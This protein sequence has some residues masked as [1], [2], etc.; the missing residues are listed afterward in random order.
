MSIYT[1]YNIVADETRRLVRSVV[2]F[3]CLVFCLR[4]PMP[5]RA[6]GTTSTGQASEIYKRAKDQFQRGEY[7]LAYS[8]FTLLSQGEK[9]RRTLLP[10]HL[11]VETEY[12]EITC[13]LYLDQFSAQAKAQEF[14]NY[15]N[16]KPWV[17]LMA[18]QLAEYY[19]RKADYA[20]ALEYYGKSGIAN[21]SNAQIAGMKFHKAY[22]HF[23][24]KQFMEAK[25]LF[26]GIRQLPDD[27]NY[28]ASNYYFGFISFSEKKYKEAA[29]AFAIAETKQPYDKFV[30]FY[31]SEILYFNNEK[32]KALALAEKNLK[33]GGQFYELQL[34]QLAG[35]IYLD[36]RDYKKALP[37]LEEYV[38]KTPKPDRVD[39]YQLSYCYYEAGNWKKCI[40]GFQTLGGKEDS[41]AQNSMYLLADAYL[42]TDKKENAR[43]AFLFCATNSSNLSQQEVSA[44]QYAKISFDLGY[45]DIAMSELKKF[46]INYPQSGYQQEAKELMVATLAQGSNYK[47]S[48]ELFESLRYQSDQVKRIYPRILYGRAVELYNDRQIVLADSLFNKI[49]KAAFNHQQLPFTYYWKGEIAYKQEQPD[50]A[51]YYFN[52][53]LI[54]PLG[55]GDVNT[56]NA[57]YTL[58][59]AYLKKGDFKSANKYYQEVAPSL[60]IGSTEVQRDAYLRSGDCFYMGRQYPKANTVYEEVHSH[61]LKGE[62]YAF[63]QQAMI[64]GATNKRNEKLRLLE[65]FLMEYPSS[66]LA[67]EANMELADYL[68]VDEKYAEALVPLNKVVADPNAVNVLPK[69]KLKI[70]VCY[71]NTGKPDDALKLFS[72][73]VKDYPHTD[74]SEEACDYIREIYISKQQPGAYLSFMK[75]AGRE[76]GASE[77]DSLTYRAAQ[78]R[79][80]G[81]DF[82]NAKKGLE[83]YLA[84]FPVGIYHLDASYFL[85]EIHVLRKDMKSALPLYAKV[86]SRS[87]N[88]FAERSA[89]QC[90]RINYFNEKN[91]AVAATYFAQAK[92]L[93]SQQDNRLE[94]MRGLLRCQYKQSQFK[95]A[96]E[97]AKDLLNETGT[98]NDDK[99]MA[100]MV[101]AKT[102]QENGQYEDAAGYFKQTVALGR[103]EYGAEAQYRYAELLFLQNRLEL[104]EAGAFEVIKKF[105]SYT[106]WVTKAYILLGDLYLKNK[107]Y[108]NA[109]ATYKSVVENSVIPELKQ[110][111][112]KKTLSVMQE[113]RKNN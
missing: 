41:L 80:E 62:D 102:A 10:Y 4:L 63:F 90:A 98:A 67:P 58:G 93:S 3:G 106:Y 43:S 105:G 50:S 83:D 91:Y 107:D 40:E 87:P 70:G 47:E 51:I 113:K 49:L 56:L 46:I 6:Q 33:K 17:Q 1:I 73:V 60:S 82:A 13:G 81:K 48:L 61:H 64:A 103:S 95:E 100:Y 52:K 37:Y 89:L 9:D 111:A 12:Y 8:Q 65:A 77:A 20:N 59:Y 96:V 45:Y 14:V 57:R 29:E 38:R 30:P 23:A 71:F 72:Q 74:E 11:Q 53:Y 66:S 16:E 112:S 88:R 78:L 31:M 24:Q 76:V 110:E 34:K 19:Y 55:N 75:E 42:K 54:N 21:L 101:L 27:S 97:N 39:I 94:A 109:E 84:E 36:K 92:M 28:H 44:F 22:S 26:N 104:V 68:L 15:Q 5:A 18:Y 25:P 108:F 79:Y 69:A 7:A 35:C 2:V 85:A 86:A 32:E 99:M